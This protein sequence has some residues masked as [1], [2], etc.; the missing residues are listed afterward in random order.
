MKKIA[1]FPGSFSP[2]T[3]G[4]L[5]I[6]KKSLEV[7]DFVYIGIGVNENK[8]AQNMLKLKERKKIITRKTKNMKNIKIS[9][10]EGLTID[11]CIKHK[12]QF[13]IRGLRDKKDFEFEKYIYNT[14]K[15][16]NKNIETI[17]FISDEDKSEIR[18]SS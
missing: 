15:S 14:N 2:F 11:F 8:D 10:Y 4:H 12:I 13:M 18:S 7:F 6:L 9:S 16:I 3:N 5:H 1:L 17:Y